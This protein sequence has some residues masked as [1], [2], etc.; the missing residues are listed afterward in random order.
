MTQAGYNGSEM[1]VFAGRHSLSLARSICDH[2]KM[3]L[4]QANVE[5]FPD[6]ELL[7]ELKEDV[8][9]RDCFVVLS[10]C[11]PVN[12]NLMELLIYAD[13]LRRAS[14]KRLTAVIPYF[15]Y[16]RQDRKD[17]GRTPITAKLVAN[18]ITTA[19]FHRVLALDLH[20]AQLQGF[21][22]LPVDHLPAAPVF[23]DYLEQH[24]E[25][26]KNLVVVSPDVGNVKIANMYADRLGG[27]LAIVHKRR[28]SGSEVTANTLVGE[29]EGKTVLMV[30]DMISTGGTVC[31]AARVVME[32]GAKDCIACATH[33]VMVGPAV[34]RIR[35]SPISKVIVTDSVPS[36][37]RLDPIRDRL[38]VL[39][40]GRL[41]AEAIHHI[42]H[43]RSV[44][45]LFNR[46]RE[47]KR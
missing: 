17:K 12:D 46:W 5:E 8:R 10:T 23:G 15:G 21:F 40:V 24:S 32:H 18:L 7:V 1:K 6:G 4:G 25:L 42:H 13:S 47:S 2:L 27:D 19:G 41:L 33:A 3:P 43:D 28:I 34:E 22:D 9:G 38:V 29:V 36:D 16:A 11:R 31:E 14:A 20:A 26:T 37:G 44:S 30:D 35:K 39:G 45:A